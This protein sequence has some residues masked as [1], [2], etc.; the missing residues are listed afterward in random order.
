MDNYKA[1]HEHTREILELRDFMAYDN[2]VFAELYTEFHTF[3]NPPAGSGRT[4]KQGDVRIMTN[5]VIYNM[6]DGKMKRIRIAH[7]RMHDPK[8]AKFSAKE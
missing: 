1:L 8:L 6:E 2:L 3:A 4:F 5:W 7:F